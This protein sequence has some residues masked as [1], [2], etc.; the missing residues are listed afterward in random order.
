MVEPYRGPQPTYDDSDIHPG[1]SVVLIERDP[2]YVGNLPEIQTAA[3]NGTLGVVVFKRWI[4]LSQKEQVALGRQ[5]EYTVGVRF[6]QR[7]R[8]F[9]FWMPFLRKIYPDLKART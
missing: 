5:A 3:Q 4:I 6:A 1:D 9:Q 2:Y 7:G 8:V